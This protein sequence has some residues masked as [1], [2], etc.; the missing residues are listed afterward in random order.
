MTV[1]TMQYNVLALLTN[2]SSIM[3]NKPLNLC[4]RV[5][6]IVHRKKRTCKDRKT[7]QERT[8]VWKKQY[9]P[10]SENNSPDQPFSQAPFNWACRESGWG[11][12]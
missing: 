4:S 10:L 5:C 2:P 3:A 1:D 7:E 9:Y 6:V 8:E 11:E 12:I